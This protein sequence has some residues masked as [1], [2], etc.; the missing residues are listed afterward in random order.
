MWTDGRYFLQA[1]QQLFDGWSLMRSGEDL[2]MDVWISEVILTL[3]S[4]AVLDK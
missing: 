3:L 2:E 4:D 1:T